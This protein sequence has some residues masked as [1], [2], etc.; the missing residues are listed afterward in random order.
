MLFECWAARVLDD[1]PRANELGGQCHVQRT[2]S[3]SYNG[4]VVRDSDT[5][6]VVDFVRPVAPNDKF[7]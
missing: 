4:M 2:R 1:E 7:Y 6:L 5:A 3:K